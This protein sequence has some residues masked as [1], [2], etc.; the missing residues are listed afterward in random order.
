[1]EQINQP[2]PVRG[3]LLARGGVITGGRTG[4]VT[5][6]RAITDNF[7]LYAPGTHTITFS[8]ANSYSR[9]EQI[10][11]QVTV[12][13]PNFNLNAEYVKLR[14]VQ[15]MA[16]PHWIDLNIQGDSLA[17][18]TENKFD[19][20]MEFYVNGKPW[21]N[22]D[23]NLAKYALQAYPDNPPFVYHLYLGEYIGEFI[24]A[25]RQIPPAQIVPVT[26]QV[27]CV[28]NGSA[29]YSSQPITIPIDTKA[30]K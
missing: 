18:L 1:M 17:V 22:P 3:C 11:T 10:T 5:G 23:D 4:I 26:I 14:I 19:L 12:L 20:T 2:R 13:Q 7:I 25:N 28:I 15:D 9:Q 16:F 24:R 30:P 8:A 21:K 29:R 27:R 6:S